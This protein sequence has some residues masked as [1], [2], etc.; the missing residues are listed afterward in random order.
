[1]N[2]SSINFHPIFHSLFHS[3]NNF[4]IQI[5]L[6]NSIIY[7]SM[8]EWQENKFSFNLSF[9]FYSM[10][11][12]NVTICF[13]NSDIFSVAY[14]PGSDVYSEHSSFINYIFDCLTYW[15]PYMLFYNVVHSCVLVV[16]FLS[17]P[18]SEC[19]LPINYCYIRQSYIFCNLFISLRITSLYML[20]NPLILP[21]PIP[22]EHTSII[23][24]CR[25][26]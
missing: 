20:E 15:W 5:W 25:V 6:R 22:C 8:N 21:F 19:R 17:L 1:M 26:I 11:N 13:H 3:M 4:I 7:H 9:I 2:G 18:S 16:F 12:L 24:R 10:N 14:N 23:I